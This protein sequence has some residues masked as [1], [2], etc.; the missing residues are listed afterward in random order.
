MVVVE[1]VISFHLGILSS[2]LLLNENHKQGLKAS[3]TTGN[4]N[5]TPST[6]LQQQ[7]F[8]LIDIFLS[9]HGSM[10]TLFGIL[11]GMLMEKSRKCYL[12]R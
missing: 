5:H 4:F 9:V 1:K 11:H 12:Y 7:K 8:L 10:G 6:L 2:L 3:R